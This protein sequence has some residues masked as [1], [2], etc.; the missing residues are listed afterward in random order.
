MEILNNIV[1]EMSMA[2]ANKDYSTHVSLQK[3]WTESIIFAKNNILKDK[4]TSLNEHLARLR[5]ISLANPEQNLE[6]Y[7]EIVL[8]LSAIL[9]RNPAKAENLARQHV[10]N[11]KRRYYNY[12]N[13]E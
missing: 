5:K 4:L 1:D 9:E 6:A 12:I 10:A 8:T 7:D 3:K 11:A 13:V 2:V